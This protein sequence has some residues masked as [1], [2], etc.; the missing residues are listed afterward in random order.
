MRHLEDLGIHR[1]HLGLFHAMRVLLLLI[2]LV[3]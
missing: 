1:N 3:I 2:L